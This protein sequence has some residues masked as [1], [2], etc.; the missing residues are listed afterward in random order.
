M[1]ILKIHTPQKIMIRII[2]GTILGSQSASPI[3]RL[4]P[5]TKNGWKEESGK[6]TAL[7]LLDKGSSTYTVGSFSSL[8]WPN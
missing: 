3:P 2:V 5:Q 4:A 8:L 7:G 1:M 6:N